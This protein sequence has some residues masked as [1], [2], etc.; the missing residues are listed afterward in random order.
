MNYYLYGIL[1]C[2]LKMEVQLEKMEYIMEMEMNSGSSMD[3]Y[4]NH[5]LH[6]LLYFLLAFRILLIL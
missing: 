6:I 1:S 2:I 5:H 3:T 4:N